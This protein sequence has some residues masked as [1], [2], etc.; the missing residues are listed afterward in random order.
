MNKGM[1]RPKYKKNTPLILQILLRK[2]RKIPLNN[3]KSSKN[4][5]LGL[6]LAKTLI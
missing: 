6:L 4:F 5:F 1:G 2:S 3:I